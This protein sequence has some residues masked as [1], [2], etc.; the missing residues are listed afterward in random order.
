MHGITKK[1]KLIG[2]STGTAKKGETE[3]IGLRIT[4]VVKRSDFKIGEPSGGLAD[5]VQLIADLEL[6]K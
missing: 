3:A 5:D 2:E 6:T 1:L 4:G